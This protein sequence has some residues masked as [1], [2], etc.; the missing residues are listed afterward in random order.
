M[1]F[2]QLKKAALP[3]LPPE[4]PGPSAL[5]CGARHQKPTFPPEDKKDNLTLSLP[6]THQSTIVR[7]QTSARVANRAGGKCVRQLANGRARASAGGPGAWLRRRKERGQRTRRPPLTISRC[8]EIAEWGGKVGCSRSD[9]TITE[10]GY[11][12]KGLLLHNP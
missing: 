8:S 10:A 3:Y 2:H 1:A 5:G 4:M 9:A 11:A 7:L 12:N 6:R